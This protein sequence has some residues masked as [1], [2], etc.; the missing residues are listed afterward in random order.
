MAIMIILHT[1]VDG[2]LKNEIK[3]LVSSFKEKE[4]QKKMKIGKDLDLEDWTPSE[5]R[6]C[7]KKMY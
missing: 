5:S 6:F 4:F 7:K 1:H 3:P 2:I